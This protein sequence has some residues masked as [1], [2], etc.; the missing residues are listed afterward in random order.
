MRRWLLVSAALHLA[1][2]LVMV[3]GLPDWFRTKRDTVM[4]Q[5]IPVDVVDIS[6]LTRLRQGEKVTQQQQTPPPPAPPTPPAPTPPAPT[7]PAPTPPPPSPTPPPK[8][9]P[10]V[11]S[12]EP[13]PVPP[14]KPTPP[15]KEEPRQDQLASVLKNVARLKN[16]LPPQQDQPRARPR[17][18]QAPQMPPGI[19]GG[20][21][22]SVG[23]PTSAPSASEAL[24]MSELDALR[25]QIEFCWNVPIG[26]RDIFDIQ[27]DILL[28]INSDRTVS[29]AILV[30]RSRYDRDNTYRAAADSAMRAVFDPRCSPLDLPAGKYEQWHRLTLSFNPSG[31]M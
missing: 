15:K 18:Q 26:A 25:R 27:V 10:P 7:P 2:M 8:P 4:L 9:T 11:E 23:V 1:F 20:K 17:P 21:G 3:L 22:P 16:Q 6:E 30:D 31:M 28:E 12:A 13:G 24:S 29:R 19:F 14:K 5:P